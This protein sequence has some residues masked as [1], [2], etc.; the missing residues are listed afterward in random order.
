MSKKPNYLAAIH[1][2]KKQLGLDDATYRQ[3]LVQVTG[4]NSAKDMT[5]AERSAVLRRMRASGASKPQQKKAAYPGRPH[6]LNNEPMLQKI[7]AQLASMKL[8]WS[9]ADA[10]AKRMFKIDKVAWLESTEQ[11]SAVI[12]SLHKEQ[13]KRREAEQ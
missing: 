8:Q 1:A 9:Y 5:Q 12:A 2:S 4:K 10:I 7:E 6:N 13:F 3:L 11:F